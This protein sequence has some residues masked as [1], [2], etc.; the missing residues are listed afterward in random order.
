MRRSAVAD[1][2]DK[3]ILLSFDD[4]YESLYRRVFPLLKAYHYPAVAGVVGSWMEDAIPT[5]RSSMATSGCH[6]PTSSPG[7][8][9]GRC[10]L[11]V[12][13]KFASHSYDL[14]RRRPVQSPGQRAAGR[15]HL[16][17]RSARRNL[18][19]RRPVRRPHPRRYTALGGVDGGPSGPIAARNRLALRAL[20]GPALQVAKQPR[21]FVPGCHWTRNRLTCLRSLRDPSVLRVRRP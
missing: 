11:R 12:S 10:S 3:T 16:A 19:G 21:L 4:G 7:P 1:C 14:H 5:A 9:R 17:L 20:H 13:S 15:H 2:R 8:R 6:A 18:R